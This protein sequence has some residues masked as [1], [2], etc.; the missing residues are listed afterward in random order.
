[1]MC[2]VQITC[3]IFGGG[4]AFPTSI[5]DVKLEKV[6]RTSVRS[7]FRAHHTSHILF[8]SL[9]LKVPIVIIIHKT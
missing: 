9:Q 4:I 3:N 6:S 7:R 8:T 5:P 1:M 2:Y